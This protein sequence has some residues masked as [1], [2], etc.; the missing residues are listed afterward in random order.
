M[1]K[2]ID[3]KKS[4]LVAITVYLILFIINILK[5]PDRREIFT[6]LYII[7]EKRTT[8]LQ[9]EGFSSNP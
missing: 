4:I 5:N 9:F 3:I 7:I 2:K 6:S 8:V 1:F